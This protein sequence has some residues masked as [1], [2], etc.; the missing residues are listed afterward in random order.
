M[1]TTRRRTIIALGLGPLLAGVASQA[2]AADSAAA[3]ADAPPAA[4]GPATP[5]DGQIIVNARRRSE[6]LQ[7]TPVSTPRCWRTRRP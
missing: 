1:G 5:D 3:A 6:T 2:M 4:S 7:T